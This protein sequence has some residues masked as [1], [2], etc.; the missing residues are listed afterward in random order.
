MYV[1]VGVSIRHISPPTP[2]QTLSTYL[3]STCVHVHILRHQI[4][5]PKPEPYPTAVDTRQ[6]KFGPFGWVGGGNHHDQSALMATLI[7]H[8][9]TVAG[10]IYSLEY[11]ASLLLDDEDISSTVQ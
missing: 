4:T 1:I 8:T 11:S 6:S 3:G 2:L 7:L 9:S 5:A 10:F